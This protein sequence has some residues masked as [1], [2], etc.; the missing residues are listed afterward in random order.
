MVGSGHTAR[1]D[2]EVS[3]PPSDGGQLRGRPLPVRGSR[4]AGNVRR[5]P[6]ARDAIA[7]YREHTPGNTFLIPVRLSD[8]GVPSFE[9]DSTTM[10]DDLQYV[11][12]FPPP[13]RAG[14]LGRLIS[15]IQA[16]RLRP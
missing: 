12:L 10:L 16:A 15:A 13:Q 2:P 6:E 8:C 11:D 14:G 7:A 5:L 4:K 1:P 9:I 3:R